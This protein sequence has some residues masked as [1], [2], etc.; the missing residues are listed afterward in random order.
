MT[1]ISE[2]EV[3]VFDAYGTLFDVNSAA[4]CCKKD[5]GSNWEKFAML[6]R[7]KQLQYSWLRTLM[8]EYISF[9]K[10]TQDALDYTLK[11]FDIDDKRIRSNLLEVYFILKS[12]PEV[13]VTLEKL[14]NHGIRSV[15]LSNGSADMLEAAIE[16]SGITD[17]LHGVYSVDSVQVFKPHPK[18]YE[19]PQAKLGS[20]SKRMYFFSSNA[21]DAC[22][23]QNFGFQTYWINRFNHEQENLPGNKLHQI[24]DLSAVPDLLGI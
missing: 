9:W 23:A 7:D 6:W 20:I 10:V 21:W 8:G 3:C 11:T 4:E 1:K 15:I 19:L 17:L 22:G 24:S 12:Y 13:R 2:L 5:L 18:A 14:K 16:N